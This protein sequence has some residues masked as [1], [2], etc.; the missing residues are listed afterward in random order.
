[1]FSSGDQIRGMASHHTG[2][3]LNIFSK[4]YSHD[5]QIEAFNITIAPRAARPGGQTIFDHQLVNTFIVHLGF[6]PYA[7]A[8]HYVFACKMVSYLRMLPDHIMLLHLVF[9]WPAERT[10]A[11]WLTYRHERFLFFSVSAAD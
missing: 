3:R 5:R 1:M 10:P 7:V 8:T 2:Q 9:I 11:Q 6:H 4:H